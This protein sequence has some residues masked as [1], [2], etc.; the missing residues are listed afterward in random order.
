MSVTISA[1]VDFGSGI[2][3][4]RKETEIRKKRLSSNHLNAKTKQNQ[5]KPTKPPK[6]QTKQNNKTQNKTKKPSVL[7]KLNFWGDKVTP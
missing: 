3:P 2:E 5:K 7:Q 4:E 6:K 1:D